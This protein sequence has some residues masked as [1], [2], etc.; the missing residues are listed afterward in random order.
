M[1]LQIECFSLGCDEK[2]YKISVI[3][4]VYNAEQEASFYKSIHSITSQ[5][6]KDFEFIIC[7][8]GSSDNTYQML[9]DIA[10]TDNRIKLLRNKQNHGLAFSLNR[11]I[12]ISNGDILVRQDIDDYSGP[13]RIE[14]LLAAF[15]K[16][17]QFALIGSNIA[18]YENDKIIGER[19]Y[20]QFPQ[21][22]DFLF[23][24]PFM[25]GAVAMKKAD[26]IGVGG[27]KAA[28]A[29]R[30]T[31]DYDLFMR[32]YAKGHLG[33]NLPQRLYYYK[34]NSMKKHLYRYRIDEAVVRYHGFYSLRLFPKG[35][36]YVVK[37]LVVGLIPQRILNRLKNSFFKRRNKKINEK[38]N[39]EG[40]D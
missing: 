40:Y 18:L 12:K 22:E 20:P 29:T 34:V 4:G 17:P 19:C 5:T 28:K 3:M 8:D 31:E 11:C 37:P 25:H 6:Y 15:E 2:L 38:I 9:A 14:I 21:K 16:N 36:P 32:L 27:Y 30:R 24:V 10:K 7:D 13:D 35:I 23:S 39:K 1:V 26:I 33:C